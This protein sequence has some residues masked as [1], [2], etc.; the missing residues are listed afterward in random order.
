MTA[1]A[2]AATTGIDDQGDLKRR[3]FGQGKANGSNI[4]E[5]VEWGLDEKTK[6]KA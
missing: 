1:R 6:Q 5:A 4:P 2:E 3:N